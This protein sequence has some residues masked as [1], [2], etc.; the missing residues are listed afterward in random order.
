MLDEQDRAE[1][2]AKR[3]HIELEELWQYDPVFFMQFYTIAIINW[4]YLIYQPN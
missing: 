2:A 4:H 1:G 3:V